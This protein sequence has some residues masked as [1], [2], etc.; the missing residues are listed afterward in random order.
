MDSTRIGV[1]AHLSGVGSR[2]TRRSATPPLRRNPLLTDESTTAQSRRLEEASGRRVRSQSLGNPLSCT[3]LGI[4]K[5][6]WIIRQKNR[7]SSPSRIDYNPL[8]PK[9]QSSHDV[10]SENKVR[11]KGAAPNSN[12]NDQRTRGRSGKRCVSLPRKSSMSRSRLISPHRHVDN[13]Q[14]GNMMAHRDDQELQPVRMR[15][16]V[17]TST[18]PARSSSLEITSSGM[19]RSPDEIILPVRSKRMLRVDSPATGIGPQDAHFRSYSFSKRPAVEMQNTKPASSNP[20]TAVFKTRTTPI[21]IS[22]QPSQHQRRITKTSKRMVPT[23]PPPPNRPKKRIQ[24]NKI[25]NPTMIFRSEDAPVR[26]IRT[27]SPEVRQPVTTPKSNKVV[28]SIKQ[29]PIISANDEIARLKF[30]NGKL[31]ARLRSLAKPQ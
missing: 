21:E 6:E 22:T 31:L 10:N 19:F 28:Y 26:G 5:Q 25:F 29:S 17:T 8:H 7:A 24:I 13:L 14:M 12:K 30:E 16:S 15:Q 2:V 4:G 1:G 9:L 18:P 20:N 11:R 23:V 3:A 27:M